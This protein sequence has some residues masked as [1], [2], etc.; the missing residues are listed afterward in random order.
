[1]TITSVVPN[2]QVKPIGPRGAGATVS[3][4]D[5]ETLPPGAEP[6]VNNVGT[7]TDAILEFGIPQGAPGVPGV[8][9]AN[10]YNKGATNDLLAQKAP[11]VHTHTADQISNATEVGTALLIAASAAAARAALGLGSAATKAAGTGAGNVLLLAEAAK[12]PA[13]DGS[14]LTNLAAGSAPIVTS[15]RSSD[16]PLVQ[17]DQGKMIELTGTFT[18]TFAAASVLGSGWFV[19]VRNAGS[20]V[21]TLD[22]NGGETVDGRTT[23]RVYPGESLLIQSDGAAFRSVGRAKSFPIARTTISTSVAQ[24]DLESFAGDDEIAEIWLSLYGLDQT[25][26]L[27]VKKNGSYQTSGYNQMFVAYQTGSVGA[28]Q[29]SNNSSVS[30]YDTSSINVTSPSVTSEDAGRIT[31]FTTTKNLAVCGTVAAQQSNLSPITGIRFSF[32]TSATKGTI[33]AMGRRA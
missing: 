19:Y 15:A 24:V 32:S 21:I 11:A 5:V 27:R 8:D 9:P 17:A 1:M 6:T 31:A 12:L 23:I 16:T 28:N 10:Y 3:I 18:Q 4:G 13:L 30:L 20:G 26:T 7:L 2:V 33:I 14:L 22:P 25:P 29:S